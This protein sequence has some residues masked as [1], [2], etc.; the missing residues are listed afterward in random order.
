MM[1]NKLAITSRSYFN[2]R[3]QR[4]IYCRDSYDEEEDHDGIM[5]LQQQDDD[6][7]VD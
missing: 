4:Q 2:R 6:M 3:R 1:S 7:D 5:L